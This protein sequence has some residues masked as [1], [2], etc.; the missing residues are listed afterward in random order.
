MDFVKSQ[1]EAALTS[2]RPLTKQGLTS[3]IDTIEIEQPLPLFRYLFH[4]LN[5]HLLQLARQNQVV[6][7]FLAVRQLSYH[8]HEL[9]IVKF[10]TLSSSSSS[11]KQLVQ[12][13]KTL[14]QPPGFTTS[15]LNQWKRSQQGLKRDD[16]I[17][18]CLFNNAP[19]LV[20]SSD[21]G[22]PIGDVF[23]VALNTCV[24]NLAD[25]D[26]KTSLKI[27]ISLGLA[28]LDILQRIMVHTPYHNLRIFCAQYLLDLGV[29]VYLTTEET[30]ALDYLNQLKQI[31]TSETMLDLLESKKQ[32]QAYW[33]RIF[34]SPA[35]IGHF[36]CQDIVPNGKPQAQ[37]LPSTK[38]IIY[39]QITLDWLQTE[40][41]TDG[42]D[43]CH[44]LLTTE[45]RHLVGE[46]PLFRATGS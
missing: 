44:W 7:Q 1:F 9:F 13:V 36:H 42:N 26:H 46:T 37:T 17:L 25:R 12:I 16:L 10:A 35:P 2:K 24:Q 18:H 39:M 3:L 8:L 43:E 40:L 45:G 23:R 27:L 28:P 6:D 11:F 14:S 41:E 4:R 5:D 22:V 20:L 31:Y 21:A 30:V 15:E 38:Q 29:K 19:Q 33:S 32:S 34:A